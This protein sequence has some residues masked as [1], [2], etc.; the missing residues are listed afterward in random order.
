MLTRLDEFEVKKMNIHD[1]Y[2]VNDNLIKI[3]LSVEKMKPVMIRIPELNVLSFSNN[4]IILD[5]REK[6]EIKNI[7]DNIDAHVVSVIQERKITKRLKTKFN[8]RQF[9]STYTGKDTVY[10][11]LVLGIT[12]NQTFSTEIYE[13]KK[14]KLSF[15]D[16]TNI[17]QNN[18]RVEIVLELTSI[19]FDK[20]DGHIYLENIVR[21]MKVRK[22]KPKRIDHLDYLF[23]DSSDS[24]TDTEEEKDNHNKKY[25]SDS[26]GTDNETDE[27]DDNK[28]TKTDDDR[29]INN[30]LSES[31][32]IEIDIDNNTSDEDD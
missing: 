13:N 19:V 2:E 12:T 17:L 9:T 25:L 27:E 6:K 4:N 29:L 10:D 1:P 24:E 15:D 18:A 20:S 7:F 3:D 26:N 23:I 5:L 32:E 22:I 28:V 14:K 8:Y 21:Q 31:E 16:A 11:I 30:S